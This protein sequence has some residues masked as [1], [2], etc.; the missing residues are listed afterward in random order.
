MQDELDRSLLRSFATAREPLPDAHFSREV[1]ARLGPAPGGLLAPGSL[2]AIL[3]A[4]LSGL[5]TGGRAVLSVR[6]A[7]IA[8]AAAAL[9]LCGLALSP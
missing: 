9:S 2:A 3:G 7:L 8:L 4:A 1:L 6:H 5:I